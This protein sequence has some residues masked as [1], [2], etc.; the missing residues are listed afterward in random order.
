MRLAQAK[1]VELARGALRREAFG[2]VRPQHDRPSRAAQQ[3]G[4]RLVLR[5]DALPRIDQKDDDVGFGDRLP[6][7]LRHLEQDAVAG[8]G[9]EAPGVDDE[10]R[11]LADR[12]RGR[13]ADRA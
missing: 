8:D 12:W 1:L 11:H 9:L 5:G 4:D 3:I 10:E 2:L 13:S 6:R 7:L